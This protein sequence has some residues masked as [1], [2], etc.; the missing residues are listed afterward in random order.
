MKKNALLC[1]LIFIAFLI[2]G[3]SHP[4]TMNPGA[5]VTGNENKNPFLPDA[6]HDFLIGYC[7]IKIVSGKIDKAKIEISKADSKILLTYR[8]GKLLEERTA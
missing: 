4:E 1:M 3:C 8:E 2:Y 7:N 5:E 6:Y